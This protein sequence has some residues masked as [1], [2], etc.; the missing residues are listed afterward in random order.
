[1]H[2]LTHLSVL[3]QPSAAI[4]VADGNL[5]TFERSLNPRSISMPALPI[6]TATNP[7]ATRKVLASFR[8]ILSHPVRQAL[9]R[10]GDGKQIVVE[11][12]QEANHVGKLDAEARRGDPAY[13]S[14]LESSY[15]AF[16]PRGDAEFSYRLLEVM[17]AGCIPV[18]LSDGWVL[19]FDRI[20]DW[21]SCSVQVPENKASELPAIL[22]SFPT[23][24]IA[25]MQAKVAQIY[26]SVFSSLD[27][28]VAGILKEAE[29]VLRHLPGV[30]EQSA[31]GK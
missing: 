17:S 13:A 29:L 22:A 3:M 24:R 8:R 14:L 20:V 2:P 19:P 30:Q 11:I 15:F 18:V 31:S 4:M 28:V 7:G 16:V 23:E 1:M 21:S 6:V 26:A 27:T 9:A 10:I 5:M 25:E 12:V